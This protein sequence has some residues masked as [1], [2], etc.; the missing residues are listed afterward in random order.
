MNEPMT[1]IIR[2]ATAAWVVWNQMAPYLLFG[3]LVAGML[4]VWLSPDWVRRHLGGGWGSSL[5]AALFGVPLPLCSCSIIP[6]AVSLREQGAGKGATAAFLMSTPQVGVNSLVVTYGLLGPFLAIV[7][8]VVAFA[9]GLLSGILVDATEK[10]GDETPRTAPSRTGEAGCAGNQPPASAVPVWRRILRHGFVTLPRAIMAP[11]LVGVTIAALLGALLP[12]EFLAGRLA[13]GLPTML[14]MLA[15][16]IPLYVCSTSSVPVAVM[17]IQSG[18]PAGAVL[19]FLITGP[20]TN[21]ATLTTLF[22]LLGA[23]ATMIYLGVLAATS[24]SAGWLLDSWILV[25]QPDLVAGHSMPE[26]SSWWGH[27][28]G[29]L[30]LAL[31]LMP[32][33]RKIRPR[34]PLRA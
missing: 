34:S 9:S 26:A 23:K 3:F 15:V 14:L 17:L 8:A 25:R 12:P 28:A 6:V 18:V 30:L 22:R 33:I 29:L 2:I 31:M 10:H 27:G 11:L 5:R 20:A 1:A 4:S 21:A 7:R 32:Y 13:P 16:G 19:V 24:L